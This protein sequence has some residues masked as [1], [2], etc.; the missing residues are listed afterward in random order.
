VTSETWTVQRILQWMTQDFTALGIGSPRLDA[1]L[2]LCSVL[3]CDRVRLY[4]DMPRP[5]A[6]EELDA[7]RAL[8][9]RRRK[10]EPVAYILGKREFYRRTFEV[11]PSVLIPRP[12]T[13]LVVDRALAALP[14]DASEPTEPA[15]VLDL[16]TGSGAIAITLATERALVHVDATDISP[17]AL[18][19][20]TRNA[21]QNGVA[22]RSAFLL[23]DLFA[24]LPRDRRY[25]VITANPPYV[26]EADYAALA[27]EITQHEPALALVAG[28]DGL[29]VLRRICT[30]AAGWLA[31]GGTL[32]LELGAGQAR[33]VMALLEATQCFTNIA[34]HR[35]LAG[36]ERV[37]EAQAQAATKSAA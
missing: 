24:P 34:A 18:A 1:E 23:G 29:D 31:P 17:E 4:M 28:A 35:D 19:V 33:A 32:L 12:E 7:V 25:A 9:Q 22:E 27:P 14:R 21:E 16:C 15:F 11:S 20:A 3:A 10:R 37:I 36:I 6:A 2:L 13:E 26:A 5:L 8:V 30:E